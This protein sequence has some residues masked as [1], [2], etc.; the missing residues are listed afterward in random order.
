MEKQI[1]TIGYEIPAFSDSYVDFYSDLSL[2]DSDILLISPDVF[3]PKGDWIQ[4]TTSDDGCYNISASSTYKQK[5]SRLKKEINDYLIAGKNVFVFLTKEEN[6]QLANSVSVTGK[7]QNTFSTEIYSN[8]S[9]LP[10][11]IGTLTSAVGKQ[12]IFNGT[13]QFREFYEK[14]KKN[15][16]Y[17]IY[18]EN[19]SGARVIFTGKDKTKILGVIYKVKNGNL[20]LLPYLKYDRDKFTE[21]KRE[22]NKRYWTNEAKQFGNS[23]VKV[24][25]DINNNLHKGEDRTPPPQWIT[26]PSFQLPQELAYIRE[27]EIKTGEIEALISQ[28]REYEIKANKEAQLKDLLFEKGKNLEVAINLALEIMGYKAQNFNDG[29]LEIDSVITS[30]E[31]VRFIGEA[32]GKDTS[33]IDIDKFRQLTMNIQEDLQ[34]KEIQKPAI[35]ILFGNGFRLTKP[36]ERAEQFTTKCIN[37]ASSSNCILIKTMD[38]F[39]VTKYIKESNNIDFAKKCREVIQNSIGKIVEF[40]EPTP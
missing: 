3:T 37:T 11:N 7:N 39:K 14:F 27:V 1:F 40:P 36:S 32:E 15:L 19:V 33:A 34:R 12:I 21:Y 28:K 4:F 35:G 23:L 29:S 13:P 25:V 22:K 8:Y 26:E 24:F 20:I 31:G 10:I 17:Q 38:L 2:M 5:M 18:L 9:F 16:E 6:Y 30:P